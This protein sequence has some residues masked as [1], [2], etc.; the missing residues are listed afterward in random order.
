M[1]VKEK[2]HPSCDSMPLQL[3]M[4]VRAF[5]KMWGID[6]AGPIKPL[7]CHMYAEYIIVETDYLTKWVEAKATIK[8]DARTRAKFLYEYVIKVSILSMK[9]SNSFRKNS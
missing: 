4:G 5:A 2:S 9:S 8:N 1:N 6:F 7:S 3:I